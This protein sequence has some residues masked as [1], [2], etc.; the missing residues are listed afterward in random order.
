MRLQEILKK[1]Y[2]YDAFRPNQRELIETILQ[3]K[4][5]MA[6]LPT[7]F[8]K[9]L[10][11][12]IPALLLEGLTIVISPLIALMEDQVQSLIEKGISAAAIHSAV[13]QTQKR[14][15][16][17]KIERNQIK[18]L[19][20]APERLQQENFI[21]LLKGKQVSLIVVDEA[22][23][24]L[25]GESFRKSFLTICDFI[26]C[27]Q[28][29]PRLLALTATATDRTK[30]KIIEYLQ[31]TSPVIFNMSMDRSDLFYG[32][33]Y[34]TQKKQLLWKTLKQMTDQKVLIYCLTIKT[35][36]ELAYLLKQDG[37]SCTFYH[38]NLSS[39][40]K[41]EHQE[42]FQTGRKTIMVCTNAFGMGIDIPDIRYVIQYQLPVCI[43]DLL[44]QLG[45]A[46][47]DH[48]FGVG[49]T[50]FNFDDLKISDYFLKQSDQKRTCFRDDVVDYC[51]SKQC[52]HQWLASYFGEKIA[53]CGCSCDRCTKGFLARKDGW[54]YNIVKRRS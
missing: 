41:K 49:I 12:Q 22:H 21:R 40:E 15:V 8:G 16:V 14:E 37:F 27:F 51:L 20:V 46:S 11:F 38:G 48:V 3:G 5:C 34:T 4:D 54:V 9:S 25:W 44:Q 33:K 6:F 7:G 36:E 53:C 1:Y 32:V 52:R 42:E 17:R 35:T 24:L 13:P 10:L 31:L 43:E 18:L 19:Y 26:S 2:G 29:R 39:K 30:E 47:R 50:F 45:R 28:P 23:T